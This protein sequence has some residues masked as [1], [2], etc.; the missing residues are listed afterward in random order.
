MFYFLIL[1]SIIQCPQPQ[2]T[3]IE[4]LTE[5]S[6][7]GKSSP[8]TQTAKSSLVWFSRS[9][10]K[11]TLR[12]FVATSQASTTYLVKM[13]FGFYHSWISVLSLFLYLF[14]FIYNLSPGQEVDWNHPQ[15]I[16]WLSYWFNYFHFIW[17]LFDFFMDSE[18]VGF[19]LYQGY[20]GRSQV[21][22]TLW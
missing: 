8:L 12:L 2:I 1:Y 20:G 14:S 5:R 6:S 22:V 10:L 4:N 3:K 21:L 17:C 9:W 19:V 13:S 7:W 16:K 11:T 18:C 15:L